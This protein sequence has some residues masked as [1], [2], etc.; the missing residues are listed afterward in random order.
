M[1][2]DLDLRSPDYV[3]RELFL[4]KRP[5]IKVLTVILLFSPL[6]FYYG[7]NHYHQ[8]LVNQATILEKEVI[9]LRQEAE[10]LLIITSEL[11]NIETRKQLI[12]ELIPAQKKW[13]DGLHLLH[14]TAPAQITITRVEIASGGSI[15]IDGTSSNMHA[16]ARYRQALSGLPV[17]GQT[18]LN[19][20]TLHSDQNYTFKIT[21]QLSTGDE[22]DDNTEKI[23]VR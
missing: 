2:Y 4:K 23:A 5:L 13:S 21:T 19:I 3:S 10:P 6:F 1:S 14:D 18:E 22:P 20:M 15:K 11:E 8:L 17:F 12:D 16:P 7:L 9:M